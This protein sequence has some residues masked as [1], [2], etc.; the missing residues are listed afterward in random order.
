MIRHRLQTALY[1]V[2]IVS[3]PILLVA[4]ALKG[5]GMEARAVNGAATQAPVDSFTVAIN[6]STVARAP[7][8]SSPES[9]VLVFNYDDSLYT[10]TIHSKGDAGRILHPVHVPGRE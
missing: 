3:L 9:E 10:L 7:V 1:I 8:P 5:P 2:S 6:G 4:F